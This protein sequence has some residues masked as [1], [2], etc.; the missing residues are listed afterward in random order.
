MTTEICEKPINR[1]EISEKVKVPY[2]NIT[3]W[4]KMDLKFTAQFLVY[5]VPPH[6]Y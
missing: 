3:E 6:S 4:V 5:K 2:H 1:L